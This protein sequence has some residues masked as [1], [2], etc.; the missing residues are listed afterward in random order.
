MRMKDEAIAVAGQDA[1]LMAEQ[2]AAA[3]N[4]AGQADATPRR[5]VERT[6]NESCLGCDSCRPWDQDDP[7]AA[8]LPGIEYAAEDENSEIGEDG[9]GRA[10]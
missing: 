9:E 4:I 7:C 6:C 5:Y 1:A 10:F 3:A 2:E 8:A